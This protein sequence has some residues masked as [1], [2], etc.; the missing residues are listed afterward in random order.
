MVV[1]GYLDGWLLAWLWLMVRVKRGESAVSYDHVAR[2]FLSFHLVLAWSKGDIRMF[3]AN[4][5][6]RAPYSLCASL[7]CVDFSNQN[8]HIVCVC[9]DESQM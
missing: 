1:V 6:G 8:L 4:L 7:E 2:S 3:Y 5:S 9:V